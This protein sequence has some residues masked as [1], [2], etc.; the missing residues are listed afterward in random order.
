LV[1]AASA[2]ERLQRLAKP[3]VLLDQRLDLANPLLKIAP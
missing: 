2:F 1:R 3:R